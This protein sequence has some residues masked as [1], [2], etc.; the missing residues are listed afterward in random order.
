MNT[1]KFIPPVSHR[2]FPVSNLDNTDNAIQN[3]PPN[4]SRIEED[5]VS[6]PLFPDSLVEP[7]SSLVSFLELALG[8]QI[9]SYDGGAISVVDSTS[10]NAMLNLGQ[11]IRGENK[12][13]VVVS[14]N[15]MIGRFVFPNE[16]VL[17]DYQ[18]GSENPDVISFNQKSVADSEAVTRVAQIDDS[19]FVSISL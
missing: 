19:L 7:V 17:V 10:S 13:S 12:V 2:Y 5:L 3:N 6:I 4:K 14:G 18:E 11:S 15:R 8:R 1:E 16:T 9:N